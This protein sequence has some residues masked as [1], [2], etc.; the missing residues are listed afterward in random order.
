[1]DFLQKALS[2]RTCLLAMYLLAIEVIQLTY[3]KD[4]RVER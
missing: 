4:G 2:A 3:Q 1:M